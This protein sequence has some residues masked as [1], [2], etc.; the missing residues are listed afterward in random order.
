[1]K[2]QGKFGLRSGNTF[3]FG[4]RLSTT[5]RLRYSCDQ[6]VVVKTIVEDSLTEID[7][8]QFTHREENQLA[9]DADTCRQRLMALAS[10]LVPDGGLPFDDVWRTPGDA[11]LNVGGHVALTLN[12]RGRWLLPGIQF[13]LI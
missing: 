7:R 9:G 13:N 10:R 4:G 11:R 8:R 3:R 12:K 1:M 2:T 5:S 6:H